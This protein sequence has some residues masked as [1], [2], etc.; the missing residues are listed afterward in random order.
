MMKRILCFFL[1]SLLALAS[2]YAETAA[3]LP[4]VTDDQGQAVAFSAAGTDAVAPEAGEW[5]RYACAISGLDAAELDYFRT[6]MAIKATE[7]DFNSYTL[8]NYDEKASVIV[9]SST[10]QSP[11]TPPP[12]TP[13]VIP[14]PPIPSCPPMWSVPAISPSS[15]SRTAPGPMSHVL[16]H[17]RRRRRA[18]ILP[19]R[20]LLLRSWRSGRLCRPLR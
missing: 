5:N 15:P 19:S 17:R 20:P 18:R 1:V 6:L 7:L 10:R 9:A 2:A 8:M 11:T 16:P 3:G 14:R 12:S 4:G 13:R